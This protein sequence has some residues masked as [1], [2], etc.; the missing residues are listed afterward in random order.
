MEKDAAIDPV[1]LTRIQRVVYPAKT[2]AEEI[3]PQTIKPT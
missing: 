3:F 2:I 1:E